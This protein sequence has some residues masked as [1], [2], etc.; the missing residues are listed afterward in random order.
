[1][2]GLT[3]SIPAVRRC[4]AAILRVRV[5]KTPVKKKKGPQ[6][7]VSGA[8]VGSAFAV[9]ADKYLVTAYHLFNGGKP[10]LRG[11]R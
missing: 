11:P 9:V 2:A 1:M 8:L 10:R 3:S 7:Q 4:V 6:L 5:I